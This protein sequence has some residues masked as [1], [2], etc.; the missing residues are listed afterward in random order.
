MI[1]E[2]VGLPPTLRIMAIMVDIPGEIWSS[3]NK[4]S[5]AWFQMNRESGQYCEGKS[6]LVFQKIMECA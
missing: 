3:E 5:V 2:V 4:V 6:G 1:M